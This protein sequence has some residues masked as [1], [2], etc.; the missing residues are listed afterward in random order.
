VEDFL[1]LLLC[2]VLFAVLPACANRPSTAIPIQQIPPLQLAG[3]IITANQ[4]LAQQKPASTIA[5]SSEITG[6]FD[7]FMVKGVDKKQGATLLR[8]LLLSPAFLDIEYVRS[9]NFT[10]TDVFDFRSANCISFAN[11]YIALARHY[12]MEADYQLIEKYPQWAR[13]GNLVFMDIHVNASVKLNNSKRYI[14]D[15]SQPDVNDQTQK[16][17][18]ARLINDD[19]AA[20][21]F[22]SNLSV[23]AIAD[24]NIA[25]AYK[26]LVWSLYQA[27]DQAM[28]WSNLGPVYRANNQLEDAEKVYLLAL[29]LDP[30][31]YAAINNLAVL[32][33]EM[34]RTDDYQNYLA[35]TLSLRHKNPYFYFYLA[36]VSKEKGDYVQAIRHVRKAIKLK[37][38]AQEFYDLLDLLSI[39]AGRL[40]INETN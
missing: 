1:K 37:D 36:Y 28:F 39:Q 20:A 22:Y 21:L 23:R 40:A 34:G 30:Q 24:D 14:V 2:W 38:D 26:M 16:K 11:L 7:K 15:I 8:S 3:Q 25:E 33:R 29:Q 19:V 35:K 18:K 31:S 10:A 27:S 17:G 5:L 13:D 4:V 9:D 12:G 32:Y 6:Y